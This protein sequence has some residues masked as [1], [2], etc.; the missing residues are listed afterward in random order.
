MLLFSYR[1][2]PVVDA[3][4]AHALA[5]AQFKPSRPSP[6]L[7]PR[8]LAAGAN[9]PAVRAPATPSCQVAVEHN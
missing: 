3:E 4:V 2:N 1:P 9:F 7:P 6:E 8:H 5:P